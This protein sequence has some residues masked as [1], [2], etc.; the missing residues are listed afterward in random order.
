MP[1]IALQS[2]SLEYDARL[3]DLFIL[4]SFIPARQCHV[5]AAAKSS[6]ILGWRLAIAGLCVAVLGKH[7]PC[8]WGFEQGTTSLAFSVSAVSFP[9][10]AFA[11]SQVGVLP[12]GHLSCFPSNTCN[13]AEHLLKYV[14]LCCICLIRK[15][16]VAVL[17]CLLK[18]PNLSNKKLNGQ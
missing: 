7:V 16:C 13:V 10:A 4:V 9:S 1:H 2:D 8:A 5:D 14:N 15:R 6:A 18:A 11:F 17:P 12:S 3:G